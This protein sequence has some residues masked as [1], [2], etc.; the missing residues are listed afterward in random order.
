LIG[1]LILGLFLAPQL[2]GVASPE[3]VELSGGQIVLAAVLNFLAFAIAPA[4]SWDSSRWDGRSS[5]RVSRPPS[6]PHKISS[7]WRQKRSSPLMG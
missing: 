2:E 4:S 6:T 7:G 1:G 5:S 3:D